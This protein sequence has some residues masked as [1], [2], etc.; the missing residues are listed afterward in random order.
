M[1]GFLVRSFLFVFGGF[2]SFAGA[3]MEEFWVGC[4]VGCHRE[5]VEISKTGATRAEKRVS[6]IFA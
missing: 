3:M 1:A 5:A 4:K 2:T 6:L